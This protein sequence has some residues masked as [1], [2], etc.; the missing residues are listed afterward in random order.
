MTINSTE[1]G[2]LCGLID[3]AIR[4]LEGALDSSQYS[5]FFDS[6]IVSIIIKWRKGDT[7]DPSQF[8]QLVDFA[9]VALAKLPLQNCNV[10]TADEQQARHHKWCRNMVL[11]EII[12]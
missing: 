3:A 10:G 1:K 4:R 2:A 6:D 9:S 12:R 7:L 11:T 5:Q 8:S